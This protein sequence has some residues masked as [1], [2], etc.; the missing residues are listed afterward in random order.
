METTQGAAADAPLLEGFAEPA[1]LRLMTISRAVDLWLG[2]LERNNRSPRT[3]DTYRRLLD[4]LSDAFPHIDIGDVSTAMVRHFLDAQAQSAG[5]RRRKS[6]ATIAQNVTIVGGFFDWLTKEGVV[7]RNPGRRN[8]DRIISRPRQTRPDEN[9]NVVTVSAD[10]VRALLAEANA[11]SWGERIAVNCLAYLGPRRR[12]L[13]GARRED[14]DEKSGTLTFRE[15]GSKT[16]AKPVPDELATILDAAIAAG[17]YTSPDAYLV[18]SRAETRRPGTRDDRIVWHLVREVAARAGVKTHVHALRAA[19]AVHYL[20]THRD[21]NALFALKDLMG[22]AR[23]ETTLVYLRRLDRRQSMETVRD[24]S[25]GGPAYPETP[26]GGSVVLHAAVP[27]FDSYVYFI[28]D[29]ALERRNAVVKIGYAVNLDDRLRALQTG[30]PHP[31]SIV[32][33]LPGAP[34]RLESDLHQL[35]RADRLNGEWFRASDR[36]RRFVAT[37]AYAWPFESDA[38]YE[39]GVEALPWTEKEGFEPSF[40]DEALLARARSQRPD[41]VPAPEPA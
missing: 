24:L 39:I 5:K 35:F 41:V 16:I 20:E 1:T 6:P 3:V 18:P 7:T 21:E 13:A 12:A 29:G 15:K 38:I 37:Y 10:D 14:Y 31:L 2:E 36:L 9:D 8:G 4:K 22:H 28:S 34:F 40:L 32:A 27:E 30:Y 33:V 26:G 19:F 11:G 17:V 23:I 25:W